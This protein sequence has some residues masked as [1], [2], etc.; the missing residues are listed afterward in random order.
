MTEIPK[1]QFLPELKSLTLHVSDESNPNNLIYIHRVIRLTSFVF[2][3]LQGNPLEQEEGYRIA[4]LFYLPRLAHLDFTAVTKSD[5]AA[6]ADFG[7]CYEPY[8][9][10]RHEE[11]EAIYQ[12]RKKAAEITYTERMMAGGDELSDD[13]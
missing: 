1:L 5:K 2:C 11:L 12:A 4:V 6:S 7:K 3:N 8:W 9:M 13:D 10:K